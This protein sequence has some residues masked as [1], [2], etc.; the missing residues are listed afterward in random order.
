MLGPF[1]RFSVFSL[2]SPKMVFSIANEPGVLARLGQA[3][4]GRAAHGGR[5]PAL[6]LF[7][8]LS[9]ERW[10]FGTE[11]VVSVQEE[12]EREKQWLCSGGNKC[13][14]TACYYQG[15]GENKSYKAS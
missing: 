12:R 6:L 11:L 4:V 15:H 5:F 2:S 14:Q 9:G 13:S 7:S 8:V 10:S 3:C 1:T